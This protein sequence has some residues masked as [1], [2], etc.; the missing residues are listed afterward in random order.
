MRCRLTIIPLLSLFLCSFLVLSCESHEPQDTLRTA[1]SDINALD[2]NDVPKYLANVSRLDPV[3][4]LYVDP[5]TKAA[6]LQFFAS[7]SRSE[8]VARA[9]LDNCTKFGVPPALGFALA[10]EESDFQVDALN[11][12]G[13]SV[14]RGLFQLNSKSYPKLS[15]EDFY[16]PEQNAKYGISQLKGCLDEAGNE[17]AALAM[18]NAGNGRVRRD[19]TPKK[20]LNYISRI[21]AY[22]QNISSLFA[23]KV[24]AAGVPSSPALSRLLAESMSMGLIADTASKTTP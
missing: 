19:A 5:S 18:Y 22:E 16:D 24:M 3:T 12:N 15:I 14:D 21:L 8:N 13:D 7:V 1:L 23:A 4:P 17:V 20:T 9:I 10:Q 6:T 2:G 11:K